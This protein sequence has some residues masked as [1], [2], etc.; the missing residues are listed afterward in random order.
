MLIGLLEM[1]SGVPAAV[2]IFVSNWTTSIASSAS[3]VRI[4]SKIGVL[5]LAGALLFMATAYAGW[6]LWRGERFGYLLSAA[7]ISAQVLRVVVPGFQFAAYCP[8]S[9]AFGWLLDGPGAGPALVTGYGL[10]YL[11]AWAPSVTE[12]CVAVNW[13][14]LLAALYLLVAVRRLAR[15]GEA[16]TA[17]PRVEPDGPSARGLTP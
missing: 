7:L 14:A 15:G 1:T 3:F 10:R 4:E 9:L 12:S 2:Y 6:K 8:I 5:S 17:Q 13:V 16:T 11:F